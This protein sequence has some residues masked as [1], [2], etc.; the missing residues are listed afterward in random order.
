MKEQTVRAELVIQLAQ[1]LLQ[2]PS[3]RGSNPVNGKYFY[4]TGFTVEKRKVKKKRPF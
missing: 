3:V 2:L 4:R 1:R